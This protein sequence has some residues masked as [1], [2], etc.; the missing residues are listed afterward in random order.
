VTPPDLLLPAALI[1]GPLP[2]GVA[3]GYAADAALGLRELRALTRAH[4]A[5]IPAAAV[6][7][8]L[9]GHVTP[10]PGDRLPA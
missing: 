8:H 9:R 10:N 2:L 6:P 1:L 4:P 3:L 7:W 5:G